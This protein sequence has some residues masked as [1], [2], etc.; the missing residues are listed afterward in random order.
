[1]ETVREPAR[2]IPVV[3]E[4]DVAVVGGGTAGVAAG[5]AAARS[6]ADT[7]LIERYNCLG[8]QMTAGY[9]VML[10]GEP[11]CYDVGTPIFGGVASEIVDCL[12][13]EDAVWYP[14]GPEI[15]WFESEM[16]KWVAIFLFAKVA[17]G[18][19]T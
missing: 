17:A 10:P 3:R 16:M 8:G 19:F 14:E 5:V 15:L 2:D 9:V 18:V 13:R 6:G 1:M 7:L 12:K 11:W 4:V